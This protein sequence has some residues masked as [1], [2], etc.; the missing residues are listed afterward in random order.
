MQIFKGNNHSMF[1]W[2]KRRHDEEIDMRSFDLTGCFKHYK[3][4]NTL[5]GYGLNKIEISVNYAF[6]L[7]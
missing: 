3:L 5:G 2:C 7:K 6:Q 4:R 1:I